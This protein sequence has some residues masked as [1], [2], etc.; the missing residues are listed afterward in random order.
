MIYPMLK[1]ARNLLADDGIVVL[2]IDDG[3]I[4]TVT[5]MLN[6]IFGENNRLATIAI[7]NNPSGRSTVTGAA[8]AHEYALFYGKSNEAILGR[9][10]R[11]EKQIERYGESDEKGAFEWVN[12]RA[13]YSTESPKMAYPISVKKN[14]SG[15]RIPQMTWNERKK[16]YDLRE[17]P[18]I[19]EIIELPIDESGRMRS[20]KWSLE[21]IQANPSDI[22]VR[23]NRSKEPA[24]YAKSRMKDKGMLPLTICDDT[25]YSS[26]EYGANLLSRLMGG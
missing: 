18:N 25:K 10:P 2:T 26:T 1:V 13:R 4:A 19:D 14:G 23:L 20:W 24:V 8:I 11:N 15:Y 6:E 21:R 12:F 3:E 7:K 5:M 17:S 22:S 16:K 9:L